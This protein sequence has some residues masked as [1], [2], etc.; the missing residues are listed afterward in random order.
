MEWWG[1]I[2]RA[3][4]TRGAT[5]VLLAVALLCAWLGH[6]AGLRRRHN[7]LGLDVSFTAQI[8]GAAAE[9]ADTSHIVEV[10]VT[11]AS[12]LLV[13]SDGVQILD[14]TVSLPPQ[15]LVAFT[16]G[17]G[18]LTDTHQVTS[19]TISYSGGN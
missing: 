19:P 15:V 3:R 12:H 5:S 10:K 16:G 1:V 14:Q 6:S 9:G 18:S 8:S 17:N 2:R 11:T 13:L 4:R 7:P